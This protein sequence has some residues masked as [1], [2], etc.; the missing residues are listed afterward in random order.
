MAN[1]PTLNT[2]SNFISR[3]RQELFFSI[4]VPGILGEYANFNV[5]YIN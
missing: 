5:N 2:S 4:R 3:F 1:N